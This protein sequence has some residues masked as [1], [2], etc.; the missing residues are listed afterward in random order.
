M[1]DADKPAPQVQLPGER[2]VP[3]YRRLAE[4]VRG[5]VANGTYR[6]GERIPSETAF[7]KSTGLSFLTVRQAL[8]VLVDEG[9]LE[10]Y[11]G[12]GTFVTGLNWRKA[13]FCLNVS[14]PGLA[15]EE[16]S[17]DLLF[18]SVER[19]TPGSAAKLGVLT[20]APL[21]LM[22]HSFRLP[23]K[24]PFMAE[25]GLVILDPY[26]PLIEAE[27]SGSFLKGLIQGG[28]QG[29]LKSASLNVSPAKLSDAEA[30][31]FGRRAG[32]PAVRLDYL[33]FDSSSRPVAAGSYTAP[34]GVLTLT[35]ELGLPLD[36]CGR[37]PDAPAAVKA[38]SRPKARGF[39]APDPSGGDA[40]SKP[41]GG[42]PFNA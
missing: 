40:P 30:K 4:L 8:K 17:C 24:A 31:L 23:G 5:R 3:Q 32:D 35:A 25:E 14:D 42:R 26:R 16:F 12:R 2:E 18:S 9:I 28:A 21:A 20:G 27:L 36:A 34:E 15:G 19:A 1:T 6:P 22:R 39:R 33:F 37:R 38:G 11:P 29:L 41:S 7:A 10:R 13:A